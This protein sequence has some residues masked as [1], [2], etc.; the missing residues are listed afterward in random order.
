M[1]VVFQRLISKLLNYKNICSDPFECILL[2]Y[3]I[4]FSL[5]HC[6]LEFVRGARFIEGDEDETQEREKGKGKEK[7]RE[8]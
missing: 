7:A 1:F 8:N 3:K 5:E 2:L 4:I 6:R